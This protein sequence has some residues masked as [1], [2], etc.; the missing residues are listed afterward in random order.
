MHE[1]SAISST[2]VFR[3]LSYWRILHY[4]T[5]SL[6]KDRIRLMRSTCYLFVPPMWTFKPLA[7][8]KPCNKVHSRNRV[9]RVLFSR[10]PGATNSSTSCDQIHFQRQTTEPH[11]CYISRPPMCVLWFYYWVSGTLSE[12]RSC[13]NTSF[14]VFQPS[15]WY[16]VNIVHM[17]G[18]SQCTMLTSLLVRCQT[19]KTGD[20]LNKY[21]PI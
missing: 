4:R 18:I 2:L 20:V 7:R 19:T 8:F 16:V 13:I 5:F 3:W 6:P 14:L 17:Y 11:S 12:G 9:N 1:V 21:F 15:A 10:T